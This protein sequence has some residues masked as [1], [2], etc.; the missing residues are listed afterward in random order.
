LGEE[1]SQ[2]HFHE[3]V[4]QELGNQDVKRLKRTS[5]RDLKKEYKETLAKIGIEFQHVTEKPL[6][7]GES[8]N[9]VYPVFETHLGY[10]IY[11]P[12]TSTSHNSLIWYLNRIRDTLRQLGFLSSFAEIYVADDMSD[13]RKELGFPRIDVSSPDRPPIATSVSSREDGTPWPVLMCEFHR[14]PVPLHQCLLHEISHLM[15][16]YTWGLETIYSKGNIQHVL[17][18]RLLAETYAHKL[19]TEILG[20]QYL[21][22][23]ILLAR[24][25]QI[26]RPP[27]RVSQDLQHRK[28]MTSMTPGYFLAT[29]PWVASGKGGQLDGA[30]VPTLLET[31]RENWGKEFQQLADALMPIVGRTYQNGILV[32]EDLNEASRLLGSSGPCGLAF[33]LHVGQIMNWLEEE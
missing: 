23:S 29:F 6:T 14:E 21:Y 20:A 2:R 28:G 24:F 27:A 12:Y 9:F 15:V 11:K 18:A 26:R 10:E 3:A 4:L 5:S 25:G 32:E 1:L 33:E 30:P 22:S 7:Q 31:I 16:H 19:P 8:S 17:A 13:L